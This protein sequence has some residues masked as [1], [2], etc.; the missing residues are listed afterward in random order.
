MR[1]SV[2]VVG[3]DWRA[4]T[5][6]KSQVGALL[7]EP[8]PLEGFHAKTPEDLKD[9]ALLVPKLLMVARHC[10]GR[11]LLDEDGDEGQLDFLY[12]EAVKMKGSLLAC[13]LIGDLLPGNI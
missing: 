3:F 4:V 11:K 6:V 7:K 13:L 10:P 5:S 12:D 8:F 1:E 2:C 9:G